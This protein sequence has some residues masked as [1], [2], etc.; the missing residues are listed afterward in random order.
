LLSLHVVP[1]ET[2]V[3]ASAQRANARKQSPSAAVNAV[4]KR[5]RSAAASAVVHILTLRSNLS[6]Q[7]NNFISPWLFEPGLFCILLSHFLGS[8]P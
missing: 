1:L 3:V 2:V 8:I 5:K 4:A 7:I 6:T